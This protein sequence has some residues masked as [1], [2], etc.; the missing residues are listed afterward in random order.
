M[1]ALAVL[2]VKPAGSR[3]DSASEDCVCQGEDGDYIVPVPGAHL[4]M[5]ARC[6]QTHAA[7]YLFPCTG[8][9]VAPVDLYHGGNLAVLL[10][11]VNDL[12]NASALRGVSCRIAVALQSMNCH[13]VAGP[14]CLG[15]RSVRVSPEDRRCARSL[16]NCLDSVPGDCYKVRCHHDH[17]VRRNTLMVAD[18]ASCCEVSDHCCP[19]DDSP[20]ANAV[21]QTPTRDRLFR[22]SGVFVLGVMIALLYSCLRTGEMM[23][24][25]HLVAAC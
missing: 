16:G 20:R 23:D 2:L 3:G 5:D 9:L 14:Y 12:H 22:D 10:H 7:D 18:C 17:F 6:A 13:I 4:R 19:V 24:A 1:N 15:R 21:L 25:N 11:Y 8:R